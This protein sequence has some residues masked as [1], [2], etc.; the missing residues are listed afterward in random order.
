MPESLLSIIE[1][2]AIV[3]LDMAKTLARAGYSVGTPRPT[4]DEFLSSGEAEACALLLYDPGFPAQPAR[5]SSG[6]RLLPPHI[7]L[8]PSVGFPEETEFHSGHEPLGLLSLPFSERDLLGAV[9]IGL[10]RANL[11]RRLAA[12]Q[13]RY[14]SLFDDSLAPRCIADGEGEIWEANEAFRSFMD[15]AAASR[16]GGASGPAGL[17]SLAELFGAEKWKDILSRLSNSGTVD[18]EEYAMELPLRGGVVV[19]AALSEFTEP[20]SARTVISLELFDLTESRRLQSELYHAQKMEALGRLAGSVAHDFNN[21]L[22]TIIGHSQMM[23]LDTPSGDPRSGDLDA[24]L[25]SAERASRLTRQLLGF[26]RKRPPQLRRMDL[27]ETVRSAEVFVRKLAGENI[28]F[29]VLLPAF[30]VPVDA[31]PLLVEQVLV[32]LVVNAR[33]ALISG[34][35]LQ[36]GEKD[37]RITI[38][39]SL[40]GEIGKSDGSAASRMVFL[41]VE[42]NGPGVPPELEARIFEPFFSTKEE[43]SGTGLGLAIVAS[44][45]NQLGGGI[46][47]RNSPGKGAGFTLSLP[48]RGEESVD[49]GGENTDYG[50]ASADEE[51]QPEFLRFTEPVKILLADDDEDLLGMLALALSSAGAEL[52]AVRNAGEA[53][54]ACEKYGEFEFL[55]TDIA[56]PGMDGPALAARLGFAQKGRVLYITGLPNWHELGIPARLVLEKPF[57]P[58]ALVRSVRTLSVS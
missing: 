21:I 18:V 53:I 51:R 54:L 29:S 38:R 56:M 43:G 25:K 1:S 33:D 41:S 24:V 57:R 20:E 23:K 4:L 6:S 32:N 15:P 44:I 16:S 12:N 8:M 45:A 47:L 42:D 49:K 3:A 2:D 11:E 7:L 39:V 5:P 58:S 26:S 48:Y 46:S 40:S 35:S 19:A 27:V 37:A 13:K 55:V 30:P 9:S 14:R 52:V 36:E 22:T 31:D 28:L 17:P 10:Q 34:R 50:Q